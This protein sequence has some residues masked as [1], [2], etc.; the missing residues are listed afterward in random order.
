MKTLLLFLVFLPAFSLAQWEYRGTIGKD[1]KIWMRLETY[2]DTA[3]GAYFYTSSGKEIKLYGN[4]ND[5]KG[6][7]L[8]EVND[9]GKVTAILTL[10]K[11][12]RYD[13][14]EGSWK[15]V[16]KKKKPLLIKIFMLLPNVTIAGSPPEPIYFKTDTIAFASKKDRYDISVLY[17]QFT[18]DDN[19]YGR[20]QFNALTAAF[21]RTEAE[22]FHNEFTNSDADFSLVDSSIK[23]Q[24]DLT[25]MILDTMGFISVEFSE[26]IYY[27]GAA[28]GFPATI[29]KIYSGRLHRWV[30]L[31]DLFKPNTQYLEALSAICI[32]AVLDSLRSRTRENYAA[33]PDTVGLAAALAEIEPSYRDWV[34]NGAA[35]AEKNYRSFVPT[36]EGVWI[37]FDPYQVASYVDG[38]FEVFIPYRKLDN[39]LSEHWEVRRWK[40]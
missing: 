19:S 10:K 33:N 37:I 3:F 18:F 38:V 12:I 34:E 13:T 11:T 27:L 35:P 17:P 21:A 26:Y 24:M 20:A 4:G 30:T 28:H 1:I 16:D 15:P 5:D 39:I 7:S 23:S 25:Y 6:Y 2:A 22:R 36:K 8:K 29:S 14:Y 31:A 40:K 9:D 32:P